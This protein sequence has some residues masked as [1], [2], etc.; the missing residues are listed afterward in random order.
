MS[1]EGVVD[2]GALL[3]LYAFMGSTCLTV[4]L[5]GGVFAVLPSHTAGTFGAKYMAGMTG[6]M[7]L[8]SASAVTIGPRALAWNRERSIDNA[9]HSLADKVDPVEF[10]EEFGTTIEHLDELV[11]AKVLAY[12]G[13]S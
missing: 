6:R 1:A 7:L 4:S 3:P 8:G 5:F 9:I 12:A 13:V 2:G 10:A 11:A